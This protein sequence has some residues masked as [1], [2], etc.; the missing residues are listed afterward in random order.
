MNL[1]HQQ[2]LF[3]RS[4]ATRA[5][6]R[7]RS[8]AA[9]ALFAVLLSSSSYGAD[10]SPPPALPDYSLRGSETEP[11]G[12]PT[13]PRWDGFYFGAQAGKTFGMADFGNGSSSQISYIL[14]NTELENI[15]SNWTT[16]PQS[17]TAS[18]SYGGFVGYNF[19]WG[20]VITGLEL[21]Y[22][23]MA[24]NA[25][26]TASIGPLIVPGATQTNGNTVQYAV[27]V[28]STASVA[29]HDIMTARARAGWTFDR[30][31]PYAFAGV[32]V[33][34]AD[35]TRS[36]NVFG[37]KTVT[38]PAIFDP[39]TGLL[40][41][42]QISSTAPLI[43]PRNPQSESKSQIAYGFTA[44]LGVEVGILQNLFLRAEWELVQFPNISDFR[45]QTNSVHVG[46]GMKF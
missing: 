8:A 30:L 44:G 15:V 40:I 2:A 22:N 9:I 45:V 31:L 6:A 38:T 10:Y 32:A 12:A 46:V 17:T 5:A 36:A 16:M 35:V 1:T 41:V 39:I 18:Q 29:I 23:H 25:A 19:Q 4:T 43:L 33:G 13:Y 42:P 26:A 24:L 14:A 20:E 28:A 11:V 7:G 3:G 27:S 34:Q 21:N 37:T